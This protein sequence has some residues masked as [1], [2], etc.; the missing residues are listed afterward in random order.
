MYSITEGLFPILIINDFFFFFF[1]CSADHE[2]R[3]WPPCNFFSGRQP[4]R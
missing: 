3:D 1:P 4:M 2:E